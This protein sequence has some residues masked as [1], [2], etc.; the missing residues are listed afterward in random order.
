MLPRPKAWDIMDITDLGNIYD[1]K[2]EFV[3]EIGVIFNITYP[4]DVQFPR[5]KNE[6]LQGKKV[7]LRR[8][9]DIVVTNC[10]A[11]N[12]PSFVSFNY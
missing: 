4:F 2:P 10:I 11:N 9:C 6:T 12:T 8:L 3:Q 1:C 7:I 5:N